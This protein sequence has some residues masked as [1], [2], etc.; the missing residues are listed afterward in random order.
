MDDALSSSGLPQL[1]PA[2]DREY[3]GRLEGEHSRQQHCGAPVVGTVTAET[4]YSTH[5]SRFPYPHTPYVLGAAAARRLLCSLGVGGDVDEGTS[6]PSPAAAPRRRIH[7]STPPLTVSPPP[8]HPTSL[9]QSSLL[10]QATRAWRRP[11]APGVE[12]AV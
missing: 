3:T 1:Q 8:T 6:L 7:I 10:D 11:A 4:L 2:A 5:P 9:P 12:R